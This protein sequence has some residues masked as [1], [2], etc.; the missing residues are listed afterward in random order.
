[1]KR[2]QQWKTQKRRDLNKEGITEE[3]SYLRRSSCPGPA[4]SRGCRS[5]AGRWWCA[6]SDESIRH[7]SSHSCWQSP[8]QCLEERGPKN[9]IKVRNRSWN[10]IL[11]GLSQA[12]QRMFNCRKSVNLLYPVC[13]LGNMLCI[14]L[15]NWTDT[16]VFSTEEISLWPKKIKLKL[17]NKL[18][19]IISIVLLRAIFLL[20]YI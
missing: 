20:T 19:Y 16:G 17:V 8:S 11:S 15:F 3:S 5:R 1:M 2:K 10:F 7:C 4:G 12:V 9:K 6:H 13:F 18:A 14:R